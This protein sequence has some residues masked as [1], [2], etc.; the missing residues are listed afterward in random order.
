MREQGVELTPLF[1]VGHF[2]STPL[3]RESSSQ[4]PSFQW[5]T[6]GFAMA[7]S[8]LREAGYESHFL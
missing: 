7:S 6:G 1:S 2:R 4:L 5:A 8:H 3:N